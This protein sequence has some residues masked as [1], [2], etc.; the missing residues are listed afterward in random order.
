MSTFGKEQNLVIN[1]LYVNGDTIEGV[2]CDSMGNIYELF[3]T[4]L[5]RTRDFEIVGIST[6]KTQS[7]RLKGLL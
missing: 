1:N 3:G 4:Y 2:Y 6:T 7:L 5:P